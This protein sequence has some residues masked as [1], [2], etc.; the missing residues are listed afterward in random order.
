[1]PLSTAGE[2][3]GHGRDWRRPVRTRGQRGRPGHLGSGAGMPVSALGRPEGDDHVEDDIGSVLSADR[4]CATRFDQHGRLM[5]QARPRETEN[6]LEGDGGMKTD[7]ET[8]ARGAPATLAACPGWTGA[9]H[10][11]RQPPQGRPS[12][13]L[14]PIPLWACAAACLFCALL[15]FGGGLL[16]RLPEERGEPP[17]VVCYVAPSPGID[18][19]LRGAP[20]DK[21]SSISGHTVTLRTRDTTP[22]DGPASALPGP[23]D[24]ER[25]LVP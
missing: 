19:L 23:T 24:D 8:S 20:L 13:A 4:C 16:P 2:R 1:M 18:R 7:R 15:G 9:R 25:N 12:V 22:P 11:R 21:A 10:A 14:L 5:V 17:S 3:E 6:R